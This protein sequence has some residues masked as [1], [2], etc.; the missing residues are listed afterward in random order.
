MQP[1]MTAKERREQIVGAALA[2]AERQGFHSITPTNIADEAKCAKSLV[3]HYFKTVPQL[4]RAVMRTAI[5]R[6]CLKVIAQGLAT[7]DAQAQKAPYELRTAALA[8]VA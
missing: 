3:Y 4:R 8:S 5:H 7:G 1:K 6:R 2:R